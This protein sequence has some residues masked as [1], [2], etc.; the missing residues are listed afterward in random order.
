MER[1]SR[2][3]TLVC[4]ALLM[5]AAVATAAEDQYLANYTAEVNEKLAVLRQESTKES[6]DRLNKVDGYL[7]M[8]GE[9]GHILTYPLDK[10][11]GLYDYERIRSNRRF[12]K[13]LEELS[14]M[15]S[16]EAG[17]LVTE[18]LRAALVTYKDLYANTW[19][20]V[21][22]KEESQPENLRNVSL[23]VST[24][25]NTAPA[26]KPTLLTGAQ[27]QVLALT[28]IAANLELNTTR[29]QIEDV[30]REALH[31]REEAYSLYEANNPRKSEALATLISEGLYNRSILASAVVALTP[32]YDAVREDYAV[33]WQEGTST[34]PE[35][36]AAA[37]ALRA[38]WEEGRQPHE[39]AWE[40][41]ELAPYDAAAIGRNTMHLPVDW[42]KG[43]GS[44]L[45]IL[46]LL[47][48]ETFD[49]IL[50]Y[51]G[52]PTE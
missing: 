46:P 28:L 1:T 24:P 18:G 22:R 39:V 15:P 6:I 33:T 47:D 36:K 41:D 3:M 10:E 4:F 45:K 42:S 52:W 34:G 43:V 20:F 7:E 23:E 51:A 25:T 17:V 8:I 35:S 9:S 30:V 29:P 21:T 19:A 31:Q 16:D 12:R 38:W 26:A 48:D 5:T 11:N 27:L 14:T 32:R 37:K 49:S 2:R 44:R 50:R 13:V 40:I